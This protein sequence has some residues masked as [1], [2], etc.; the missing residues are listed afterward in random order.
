MSLLDTL[1]ANLS[2][3]LL[4]E[5]TDAL[6]DDFNYDL[7]PRKRLNKVIH[8]RDE[9]R[10]RVTQLEQGGDP[11]DDDFEDDPEFKGGSP[12]P[13][14]TPK[15]KKSS[16][17]SQ[18]D[19]DKAVR[20]AIEKKDTEMKNLR[21]RFAATEKLRE[22]NFIDPELV[23]NSGLIDFTKVTVDESNQITGGLDEQVSAL[24]ESKGYLIDTSRGPKR[25][26]GKDGSSDDFGQITSREEFLKLPT[27]KQLQFKQANPD[28]FKSFLQGL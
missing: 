20:E 2:P 11:N 22:A 8:Q 5:V 27:E 3:E 25:G 19:L 4:T 14:G 24:A 21:L 18:D 6:G 17:L 15:Q 1:R 12:L 23:L 9:A 16:G 28:V 10:R 26:T 7:V 13:K